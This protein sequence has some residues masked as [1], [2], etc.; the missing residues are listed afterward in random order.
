MS[1]FNCCSIDIT[2]VVAGSSLNQPRTFPL[3]VFFLR[4]LGT[5]LR[6]FA[7]VADVAHLPPRSSLANSVEDGVV[8]GLRGFAAIIAV[9]ATLCCFLVSP[10]LKTFVHWSVRYCGKRKPMARDGHAFVQWRF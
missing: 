10:S 4:F 3:L 7:V 6:S 2:T 9:A 5:I 1:F 8:N